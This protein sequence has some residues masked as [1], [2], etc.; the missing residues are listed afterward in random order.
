M[1]IKI[2]LLSVL[3][4]IGLIILTGCSN[5]KEGTIVDKYYRPP[6]VTTSFMYNGKIMIPLTVSHPASYQLKIELE[7][8]GE[9]KSRIIY[10]DSKTYEKYDIG[11]YYNKE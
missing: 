7:V 1:K 6:F 11:D 2:I 5:I 4:L 8:D 3:V 9:K 10:V